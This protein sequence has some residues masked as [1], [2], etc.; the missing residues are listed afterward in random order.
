MPRTLPS[1][2]VFLLLSLPAAAQT[3]ASRLVDAEGNPVAGAEV[4]VVDQQ[5]TA[6]T[7]A[8]GS[9]TIAPPPRL[10]AK[11][12]IAGSRGEMYPPIYLTRFSSEVRLEPA[13]RESIT[14]SSG[15]AP[16]IEGTPASAPVVIGAEEIEQRKPAHIVEAIASTPGVTLRGEGAPAVPVVRGLAGGRTLLLIDDARIVAERRAGPSATFVDPISLA[17][18]EVSRGP[19]SVG[20][21]SDALGG[22]VH[23]RP[24]DPVAGRPEVRYDVSGAFGAANERSAAVE[25]SADALGGAVLFSLHGRAADDAFDARGE[26]IENS[27]YRARGA[28]LRF[29]RDVAWGRLRVGAMSSVARDVGAPSTSSALTL[30]PDERS[31]LLTLA[32]DTPRVSG[33]WNSA[34]V[35]ASIGL[36]SV[37]TDRIRESGTESS[38]VKARDASLR[39]SGERA[40]ARS[41]SVAGADFV[42]RFDLRASG[43]IEDADRYDIGLYG[44]WSAAGSSRVQLSAGGRIDRVATHNRG[45]FFGSRST[46]D[47]ALSGYASATA[48]LVRGVTATAQVSSGYREPSLSDRYYRGVSGRGFITGNPDLEPERSLQFDGAVRWSGSRSRLAVFGYEYRIRHLVERYRR[49]GDFYFRNRGEVTIRGVEIEAARRLGRHFELQG[50]A[51]LARGEDARSGDA[52]DD[53]APPLVH[54][55]L[56]WASERASMFVALSGY[57]RDERPGPVEVDRPGYVDAEIGAGWRVSPAFEVRLVVRNAANV[58]RFGSADA[59]AARAPGRS[60]M[61]GINR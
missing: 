22:V 49:D 14:V 13:Y 21:G 41:Q 19:G 38:A 3:F 23:L 8:D 20:Y 60:V 35:R 6:R 37:T 29:V 7:G 17:S 48:A 4:S 10:P 15:A 27:Q 56:R 18:I 34:A 40:G 16:N 28:M 1:L 24:R 51:A 25:A 61:V 2:L 57:A 11:L 47:V 9:F 53:I 44:Y 12:L 54:T 50:G 52:L 32:F 33:V 46:S 59:E 5:G 26:R 39:V 43:S 36:Y 31:T 42:S 55:S 58:D 30:Y 45:G